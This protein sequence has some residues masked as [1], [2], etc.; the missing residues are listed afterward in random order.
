MG[1]AS[2]S[3]KNVI[4]LEVDCRK[5]ERTLSQ[6]LKRE[7][8]ILGGTLYWGLLI[9]FRLFRLGVSC[10]VVVLTCFCNVWGCV[11]VGF[12]MC[13]GLGNMCTCTSGFSFSPSLSSPKTTFTLTMETCRCLREERRINCAISREGIPHNVTTHHN[14]THSTQF[15][16]FTE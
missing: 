3:S 9:I 5:N 16:T 10:T 12:V 15:K 14:V 8:C 6:R 11:C 4:S 7:P 13:G 1:Q 2:H